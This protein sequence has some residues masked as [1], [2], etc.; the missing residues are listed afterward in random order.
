MTARWDC[1]IGCLDELEHAV[2]LVKAAEKSIE[3]LDDLNR[4]RRATA[5]LDEVGGRVEGRITR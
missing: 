5:L 3:T 1:E 2:H 4:L